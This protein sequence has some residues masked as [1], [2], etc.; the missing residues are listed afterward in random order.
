VISPGRRSGIRSV[1]FHGCSTNPRGKPSELFLLPVA[2]G[3]FCDSRSAPESP[4]ARIGYRNVGGAK[5]GANIMPHQRSPDAGVRVD[6][7]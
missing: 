2:D 7:G 1:R 5:E 3:K 4:I 6:A